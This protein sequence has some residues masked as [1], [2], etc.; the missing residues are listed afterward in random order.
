MLGSAV[1]AI[2]V[3]P[4]CLF[5]LLVPSRNILLYCAEQDRRVCAFKEH[6]NKIFKFLAHATNKKGELYT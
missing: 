6:Y 4:H 1:R 5:H 2:S 3:S